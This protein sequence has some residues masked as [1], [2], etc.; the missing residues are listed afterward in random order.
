[1][2]WSQLNLKF[3]KKEIHEHLQRIKPLFGDT[4]QIAVNQAVDLNNTLDCARKPRSVEPLYS[5]ICEPFRGTV[6]ESILR[7]VPSGYGRARIMRLRPRT[8]YSVHKDT[9]WRFHVALETNGKCLFIIDDHK[10]FY[11]PDDGHVYRV[12][13]LNWHTALNGSEVDRYHLVI[14]DLKGEQAAHSHL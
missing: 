5:V 6:F 7:A 1:M 13:T 4:N 9:S 12:N 3:D 8:C 2:A 14:V 10:P 11:I